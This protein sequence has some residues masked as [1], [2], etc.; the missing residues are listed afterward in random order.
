MHTILIK[1]ASVADGTGKDIRTA[2][3]LICDGILQEVGTIEAPAAE[4]IE[5]AGL[6]AAPAFIDMH[7]HSDETLLIDKSGA[8]HL[9][10]GVLTQAV[11]NCGYSAAPMRGR[12]DLRR[13]IYGY[14]EADREFGPW[15]NFSD[16]LT[17]LD[18][19]LYGRA[20]SY[21]G[22][23][24]LRSCVMGYEKRPASAEEIRRMCDLLS[25]CM[26]QGALGLSSGLEYFPGNAAAR[27]E[28]LALCRVVA[29]YGGLYATHVRNRDVHYEAGFQEAID[30]A[31]QTGVRLQIS[32]AVP[33]YGVP[34]GGAEKVLSWID[35]ASADIDIAFDV[36]PYTWGSAVM[37]SI[38]PPDLLALPVDELTEKLREP[39]VRDRLYRKKDYFWR[40]ITDRKFEEIRL[41]DSV[42]AKEF[43]GKTFAEIGRILDTDPLYA[44]LDVLLMEGSEMGSTMM[45]G[46]FKSADDLKLMMRHPLASVISDSTAL[47]RNGL[48]GKLNWAEGCYGW[49]PELFRSFVLSDPV[50]TLPEA[51]HKITMAPADR[52][53]LSNTGRLLPGASADLLLLDLHQFAES[54]RNRE[55]ACGIKLLLKDGIPVIRDDEILHLS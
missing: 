49:V 29:K 28:I 16:Y 26:E 51:I 43:E 42:H 10:Q 37:R 11:G 54:G 13:N 38:L 52:L 9:R 32:H 40:L 22:H 1:H 45:L 2:D 14:V 31:Y 30:T 44:M 33:K 24:A 48:L 41:Y 7:T 6:L 53:G 4:T 27:E 20:V 34:A 5:A 25:A 47:N 23:G 50:L 19:G 3:L 15:E 35:R 55:Y 21:V 12:A 18:A 17:E 8:S 39:S 36:I 46:H